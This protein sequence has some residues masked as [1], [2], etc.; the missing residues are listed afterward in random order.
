MKWN[1]HEKG[2][3]PLE[4]DRE[5]RREQANECSKIENYDYWYYEWKE[6][7]GNSFRT[8]VRELPSFWYFGVG[9]MVVRDD[10]WWFEVEITRDG[11][12]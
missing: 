4:I 6:A 11:Y 5:T 7:H 3:L 2:F 10:W 12:G 9:K 8:V 1:S